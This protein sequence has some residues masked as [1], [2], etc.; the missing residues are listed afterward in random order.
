MV[1]G[2]NGD[3]SW[4]GLWGQHAKRHAPDY[5][6]TVIPLYILARTNIAEVVVYFLEN[7]SMRL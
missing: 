1:R 3:E 5:G 7:P 2:L 4:S 6:G